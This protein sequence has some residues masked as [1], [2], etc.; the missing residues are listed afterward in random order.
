MTFNFLREFLRIS[1]LNT[2]L[3]DEPMHHL[4]EI[5]AVIIVPIPEA[6]SN[7]QSLLGPVPTFSGYRARQH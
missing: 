3:A 4:N 7:V 6:V 5:L 2:N 1:I